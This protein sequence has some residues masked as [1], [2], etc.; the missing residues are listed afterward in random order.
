[1]EDGGCRRLSFERKVPKTKVRTEP[2]RHGQQVLADF[3]FL[4]FDFFGPFPPLFVVPKAV[5]EAHTKREASSIASRLAV[6]GLM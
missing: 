2:V 4:F 5:I 6:A 1:M 3:N